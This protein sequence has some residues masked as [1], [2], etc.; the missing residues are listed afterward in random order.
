MSKRGNKH[1]CSW[2]FCF[3]MI[4]LYTLGM[5]A[6]V[7]RYSPDAN[8]LARQTIVRSGMELADVAPTGLR[9]ELARTTFIASNTVRDWQAK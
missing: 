3:W 8:T 1:V 5:A 2:G 7:T 9:P 4:G 6:M